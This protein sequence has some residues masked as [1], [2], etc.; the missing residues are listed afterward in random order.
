MTRFRVLELGGPF[1]PSRTYLNERTY[2]G[3]AAMGNIANVREYHRIYFSSS[4]RG[5]RTTKHSGPVRAVLLGSSFSGGATLSDDETL[6]A[7]LSSRLGFT[8]YNAAGADL[9]D[10]R[11]LRD[12]TEHSGL[13]NGV[14]IHEYVDGSGPLDQGSFRDTD[15]S[16][17]RAVLRMTLGARYQDALRA[18]SRLSGWASE[19]P[20]RL[21]L[22]KGFKNIED[23]VI[24]PNSFADQVVRE[25][26]VNGDEILF[27]REQLRLEKHHSVSKAVSYWQGMEARL[28][29]YGLRQLV[30]LVPNHYS[31]YGPLTHRGAVPRVDEYLEQLE[32]KLREAGIPVVN[33]A[34]FIK[35]AAAEGLPSRSYIYWRDDTHWNGAGV[36]LAA[37]AIASAVR[38]LTGASKK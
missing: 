29:K 15:R 20:L 38:E 28:A 26:L 1:E 30:V 17:A 33:L 3:I 9:S 13:R 14:V 32:A 37:G 21:T 23:D 18:H 5:F 7:T 25:R 8:V 24:L 27:L 35:R 10:E 34:R 36:E 2:G 12:L 19:S 22:F 31:V 4:D 6:S 11:Q 16:R